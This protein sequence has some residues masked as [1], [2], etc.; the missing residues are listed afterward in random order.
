ML[1]N[2]ADPA[3]K[4]AENIPGD[5]DSLLSD[6]AQNLSEQEPMGPAVNE[7]LA[8]MLNKRWATKMS[9]KKLSDKL[10]LIQKFGQTLTSLISAGICELIMFRR[11]W[12]KQG[13]R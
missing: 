5:T 12:Q 9:D 11:T 7:D 13:A 2:S 8:A 10:E 3:E 4:P 1:S 6:I